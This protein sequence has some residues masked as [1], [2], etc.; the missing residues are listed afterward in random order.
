MTVL[1]VV[2]WL[3]YLAFV[4]PAFVRSAAPA[5]PAPTTAAP[6]T[7]APATPAIG[8]SAGRLARCESLAA[9]RPWPV[10][11]CLVLV[12]ALAATV[13]IAVLPSESAAASTVTVT[14]TNCARDWTTPTAGQHTIR[15][16][17]NSGSEGEINLDNAGGA[18]VAEIETIGPATTADMTAQLSPGTYTIRCLMSGQPPASSAP[19][20]VTGQATGPAPLAVRPVTLPELTGPD[21]LYQAYAAGVLA[22]LATTVSSIATELHHG[23]LAGARRSWLAAQL[24]WERVGASYDSFG[25]LGVAADGLPDGL[26]GGVSDPHFA[27]LKRLEYGLWHGQ[28]AAVL[29]PV[30]KNLAS[31]VAT[32]RAHL[33][34]D[35][36]AGDPTNLPIRAHEILED[37][38]RDHLSGLDDEGAGAAYAETYADVQVT[39]VVLGELGPL[40]TARAAGLLPTINAELAGLQQALL[41]ARS[42]GGWRAPAGTP[43]L[44]RQRI[45]GAIGAALQSLSS[46]PD[47]LEVPPSP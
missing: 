38:L 43:L 30:T 26:P 16:A 32:V 5:R 4:I 19:V 44:A 36:L 12:P 27:G 22:T 20:Q 24:D 17:N 41:A 28:G 31:D 47:L 10:A 13:A 29:L 23:D 42:D 11:T 2:A 1:Q 6:A 15:V 14:R 33:S 34:A 37:A 18:V 21:R 7:D 9:R 40:I 45:D 46:V 39:K 8:R 3:G 35:D 25:D